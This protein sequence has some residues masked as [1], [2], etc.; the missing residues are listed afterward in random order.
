MKYIELKDNEN[1]YEVVNK[2]INNFWENHL[3][4][5][6]TVVVS[7]STSYTGNLYEYHN[8]V[9]YPNSSYNDIEYLSDWWEGQKYICIHGVAYLNCVKIEGGLY[10]H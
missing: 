1:G 6:D 4:T 8:E 7:L 5:K 2:Y 9:A 3:K 10:E